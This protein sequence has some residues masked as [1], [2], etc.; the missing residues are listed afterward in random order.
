MKDV[1]EELKCIILSM[2]V[3]N[4][5]RNFL[6]I[7]VDTFFRQRK[8]PEIQNIGQ[9]SANCMRKVEFGLGQI[10]AGIVTLGAILFS[11]WSLV[12]RINSF[13]SN[14]SDINKHYFHGIDAIR[15]G[16]LH[17]A[18]GYTW[19]SYVLQFM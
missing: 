16:D 2:L 10:L 4:S 8:Q 15:L 14:V 11:Q 9:I 12:S 7:H 6:C 18:S 17:T 13:L 5:V 3:T 19:G 1:A